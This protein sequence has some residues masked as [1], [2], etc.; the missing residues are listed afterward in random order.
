MYIN[1]E[2]IFMKYLVVEIQTFDTGAVSTPTYA[3]DD[4]LSAES[5]YF[6]ILSAAAKSALPVHACVLM[7]SEGR[8]LM[9]QCYTHKVEP[10]EPTE[11]TAE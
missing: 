1:K 6:A 2:G 9:N 7:T 10:V 5:K 4:R 11:N 3:Y 8:P